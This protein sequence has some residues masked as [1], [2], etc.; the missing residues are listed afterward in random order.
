MC[1]GMEK[2]EKEEEEE[3]KRNKTNLCSNRIYSRDFVE[4]N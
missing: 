3:M 4:L 1:F 2:K